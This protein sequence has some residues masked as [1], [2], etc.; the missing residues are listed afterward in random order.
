MQREVSYHI[1]K[2]ADKCKQWNGIGV[3]GMSALG[4]SC[5]AVFPPSYYF[6]GW[7]GR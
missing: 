2:Y 5:K 7:V 1:Y 3:N 4:T 6:I